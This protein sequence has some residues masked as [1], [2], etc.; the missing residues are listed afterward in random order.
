MELLKT[1]PNESDIELIAKIVLC[2][3]ELSSVNFF[4]DGK[5][6]LVTYFPTGRFYHIEVSWMIITTS[7]YLFNLADDLFFNIIQYKYAN[8]TFTDCKAEL[9]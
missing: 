6:L 3:D 1:D 8:N 2:D 4:R 5:E 7:L 9:E